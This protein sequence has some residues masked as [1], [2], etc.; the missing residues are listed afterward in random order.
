M[1]LK[2]IGDRDV[3]DARVGTSCYLL[4]IG[5]PLLAMGLAII[6]C[7]FFIP[8][9][10]RGGDFIPW[11]VGLPAGGLFLTLGWLLVFGR[12]SSRIDLRKGVFEDYFGVPFPIKRSANALNEFNYIRIQVCT[13]VISRPGTHRGKTRPTYSVDLAGK[14]SNKTFGIY[15]TREE[16]IE[17]AEHLSRFLHFDVHDNSG[18]GQAHVRKAGTM[19]EP[20]KERMRRLQNPGTLPKPP[21][22]LKSSIRVTNDSVIVDLP[23][24]YGTNGTYTILIIMGAIIYSLQREDVWLQL[25]EKL[26]ELTSGWLVSKTEFTVTGIL[27]TLI[28]LGLYMIFTTK[29]ESLK[30]NAGSV[31][32]KVKQHLTTSITKIPYRELEDLH[33]S[34]DGAVYV[35]SDKKSFTFGKNL[36]LPESGHICDLIRSRIAAS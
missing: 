18:S 30:I 19:D 24:Q 6:S 26:A 1:K 14:R 32:M 16:A 31:S 8:A 25:A 4:I 15:G 27:L 17:T 5:L 28:V 11:L 3:I 12:R 10:T 33:L 35:R 23:T 7:T 34:N 20:L 29:R 2:R 22:E 36:S 9:E 21:D 13:K